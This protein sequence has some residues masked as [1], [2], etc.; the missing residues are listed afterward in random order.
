MD[1]P[2]SKVLPEWSDPDLL[3]GFDENEKPILK[4][5][6]KKITLRHMLTHSAGLAHAGMNPT[7]MRYFKSV[8]R[9][10][11]MPTGLIKDELVVPL[12]YEPGDGWQYATGIDWAGQAVERVNEGMRLGEYLRKNVFDP[13]G[14]KSAT[15]Q[16]EQPENQDKRVGRT[17]RGADGKV[18]PELPDG[19]PFG[20]SK[21]PVDDYGG[22]G[23]NSSAEDYIKILRSL[24]LDDGVLL[25]PETTKEL[26]RP[27]LADNKYIQAVMDI[28]QAAAFLAPSYGAG[29]KWNHGLGGAISIDGIDGRLAPGAMQW[30]GLPNSYW[31]SQN[32]DFS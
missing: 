23:L 3:V 4:K 30:A 19:S 26:F 24:L 27:Q 13:V 18:S 25:K 17:F 5:A 1:E 10:P 11:A 8:G 2:I 29:L 7:M 6:T 12:L 21:Q 31:V 22:G 15:F 14:A 16:K 20:T 28:P 32:L 9:D